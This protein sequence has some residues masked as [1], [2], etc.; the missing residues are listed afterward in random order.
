MCQKNKAHLFWNVYPAFLPIEIQ[1]GVSYYSS[2]FHPAFK[3]TL[4]RRLD[5]EIMMGPLLPNRLPIHTGDPNLVVPGSSLTLCPLYNSLSQP[6]SNYTDFSGT[7][8]NSICLYAFSNYCWITASSL[9]I[10]I[11]LQISDSMWCSLGTL[12]FMVNVQ[13]VHAR[14]LTVKAQVPYLIKNNSLLNVGNFVRIIMAGYQRS[15]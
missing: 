12:V 15:V 1:R 3:T 6:F 8:L 13:D 14:W 9:S 4:C 10:P 7:V 2:L 11:A 5:W